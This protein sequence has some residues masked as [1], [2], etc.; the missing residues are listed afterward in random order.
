MAKRRIGSIYRP[1]VTVCYDVFC[2][3]AEIAGAEIVIERRDSV[4][5]E[6]TFVDWSCSNCSETMGVAIPTECFVEISRVTA[7][8]TA[9]DTFFEDV[10]YWL[11]INVN[12]GLSG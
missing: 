4:Q 7:L 3:C 6:P 1:Y 11:K 8:H 9:I 5:E 10:K 2:F 12:E